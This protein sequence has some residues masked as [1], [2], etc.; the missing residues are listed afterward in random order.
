M[1]Q[2]AKQVQF[3]LDPAEWFIWRLEDGEIAKADWKRLVTR[4]G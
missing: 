4:M 1:G 3:R 2:T